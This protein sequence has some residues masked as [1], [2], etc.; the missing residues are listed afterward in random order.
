MKQQKENMNTTG[1]NSRT[2]G[3]I[4]FFIALGMFGLYV[5]EL[6]LVGILPSIISKYEIS[7]VEASWLVGS[8]ALII[9][10]LGPL[11][12]IWFS[13]YDR[14]KILTGSLLIFALCSAL[15]AF[16]PT[17]SMLLAIRVPAALLQAVFFSVAFTAARSLYAPAQS[18]HAIS[19]VFIGTSTGLVFGVPIT[20]YVEATISYEAAF[21]FC[22]IANV[23]A[24]VGLWFM[25]PE[26]RSENLVKTQAKLPFYV[27]RQPGLCLALL[28]V[29][30][31]FSGMMAVYS[32]SA[33]YLRAEF[34]L[35]G[36]VISALL[37]IFG[38][39]GVAGNV[40]FG[41]MLGRNL[42]KTVLIQLI[43]LAIA[44]GV[45]LLAGYSSLPVLILICFFWGMAHTS[46]MVVGQVWTTSSTS[47]EPEFVTSLFV[48]AG[49][50]GVMGGSTLS[51]LFIKW[52]GMQGVIW[53]G[54][55]FIVL[56]I[57][58]V[59]MALPYRRTVHNG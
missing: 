39:G 19:M 1:L 33:E 45:L 54:W 15:S 18:A 24:A 34:N 9:A 17:Y 50:F 30:C 4:I 16:A 21:Y 27:F 32:F 36:E 55:L 14:R 43:V 29:I 6:G 28:Q 25:L 13:R 35:N 10:L 23:V 7:I 57:G 8:F 59:F 52:F 38:V 56:S 46:G 20:A 49:N 51:A 41:R 2:R 48:S 5:I 47:D 22:T 40:L 31:L 44:Y 53:S 37:L 12:V 26:K 11:M 58:L 42:T 3:A